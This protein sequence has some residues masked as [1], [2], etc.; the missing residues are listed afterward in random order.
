MK[1]IKLIV[2]I[3]ICQSAGILGS[4]FTTPAISGWYTNLQKPS[5]APPNWVF[6]PVWISL[7]TLMGISLYFFSE[8]GL[9]DK[10]VRLSLSIFFI[11]LVL[12]TLW[13]I[14]FFGLR[15]PYLAFIEIIVLWFF[16]ILT[17]VSFYKVSRKAAFLLLPYIFWVSFAAILN[18]YIWRI[19]Y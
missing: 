4:I 11:H 1:V 15:S 13:S 3:F 2:S 18:F 16:I 14:I 7:F 10:K 9:K 17:I 6:A 12:N 8:K 5:F 19:N